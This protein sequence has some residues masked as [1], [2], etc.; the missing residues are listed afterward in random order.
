MPLST[1]CPLQEERR[2]QRI[3]RNRKIK[4]SRDVKVHWSFILKHQLKQDSILKEGR[5]TMKREVPLC[6][7]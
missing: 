6:L 3:D 1:V 4:K 2:T 5:K 7:S